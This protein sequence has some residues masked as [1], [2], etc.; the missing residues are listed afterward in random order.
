MSE[1]ADSSEQLVPID[2]RHSDVAYKN[3]RSFA[4]Y[5]IQRRLGR[6][7]DQNLGATFHQYPPYQLPRVGLV[8]D[9]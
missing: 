6:A 2:L 9:H 1:R 8:I 3:V 4:S 5:A 7:C